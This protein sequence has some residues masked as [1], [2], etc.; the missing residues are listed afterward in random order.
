MS[1]IGV[2]SLDNPN[3]TKRKIGS[4]GENLNRMVKL[5]LFKNKNKVVTEQY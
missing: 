3:S 5:E 1:E 2:A 4:I